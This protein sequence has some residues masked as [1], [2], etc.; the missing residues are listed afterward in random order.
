MENDKPAAI[1][2]TTVLPVALLEIPAG[3]KRSAGLQDLLDLAHCRPPASGV[4]D[5]QNNQNDSSCEADQCANSYTSRTKSQ[6]D[7]MNVMRYSWKF[8]LLTLFVSTAVVYAPIFIGRV[9]FPAFFIYEFPLFIH[10]APHHF[11]NRVPDIGDLVTQFYPYR[12]LT[13][14]AVRGG[15]FP[16]WNPYMTSGTVFLGNPLSALLY[17]RLGLRRF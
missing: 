4:G 3:R 10:S 6:P 7:L 1:R 16:M 11:D 2:R 5:H 17:P 13:A 8:V 9:P 15:E 12:T 14:R